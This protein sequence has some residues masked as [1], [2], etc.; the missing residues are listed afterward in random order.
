MTVDQGV[1]WAYTPGGE[2]LHVV[3]GG[4]TAA[5]GTLCGCFVSQLVLVEEPVPWH[6]VCDWCRA[7]LWKENA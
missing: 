3:Q 6:E 4:T 2:K 7:A 1:Q 5:A